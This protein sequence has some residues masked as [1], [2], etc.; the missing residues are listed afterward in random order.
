MGMLRVLSRRGDDRFKW[1]PTAVEVG[2]PEAVAAIKEAERI[3]EE[4][5]ARGATAV[6]VRPGQPAERIQQFDPNAEEIIMI[7]RVV[8]G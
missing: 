5:R 2:D 8:G 3:F 1:N 4:Q 7:P 6:R